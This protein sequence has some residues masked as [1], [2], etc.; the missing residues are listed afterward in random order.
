MSGS[1]A[2][3][4]SWA[5]ATFVLIDVTSAG[6]VSIPSPRGVPDD[7]QH[8]DVR[9][10]HAGFDARRG[11]RARIELRERRVLRRVP[12]SDGEHADRLP[13]AQARRR[14]R[15]STAPAPTI[16][17]CAARGASSRPRARSC[18]PRST[19]SRPAS[20]HISGWPV[21][22]DISAVHAVTI[23]LRRACRPSRHTATASRR[24]RARRRARRVR[25]EAPALPG[26][27]QRLRRLHRARR[28]SGNDAHAAAAHVP[29]TSSDG[30]AAR[31][32][33]SST[34]SAGSGGLRH[35]DI[36]G[37]GR[38]G[39]LDRRCPAVFVMDEKSNIDKKNRENF[40]FRD[41]VPSRG[42]KN[43]R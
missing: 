25:D 40:S 13:V 42:W 36:S 21:R 18:R 20:H 19:V 28:G 41:V 5:R 34:V 29:S 10:A 14:P 16:A 32:A 27:A 6:R 38:T 11:A 17:R 22:I 30:R 37:R 15:E 26:T 23:G 31:T 33:A 8:H 39:R 12:A 24:I 2:G 35:G 1:Q 43:R 7:V 9:V 3:G 4:I